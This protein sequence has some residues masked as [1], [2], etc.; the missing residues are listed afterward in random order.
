MGHR[1]EID[2][3]K[4]A[5]DEEGG[6]PLH[7]TIAAF[8][9]GLQCFATCNARAD[10]VDRQDSEESGPTST[11][12]DQ[13]MDS[14]SLA[15]LIKSF[16][17]RGRRLENGE[18]APQRHAEQTRRMSRRRHRGIMFLG[19]RRNH[20]SPAFAR[21]LSALGGCPRV[22][23]PWAF[24]PS[25]GI[26]RTV[27]YDARTHPMPEVYERGALAQQTKGLSRIVRFVSPLG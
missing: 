7:R 4:R 17:P 23:M 6:L 8:V 14:A 5:V 21:S 12:E 22:R 25:A 1:F 20:T 15:R 18:V 27:E 24:T 11:P 3:Y 13:G 26:K 16:E 2:A 19:L 9:R 10:A